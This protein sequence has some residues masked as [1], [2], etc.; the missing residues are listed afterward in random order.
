MVSY[1]NA[2]SST[3]S[4]GAYPNGTT[5]WPTPQWLVDQLAAEFAP[6]GF[7]LDPAASPENTKAPEYFTAEVDGLTRPWHGRVWCNPPY[8]KTSTP[9]WLAKAKAEVDQGRAD[10][11]VCLV[12]ARVETSWWRQYEADPEVFTRVIGR[13]KWS[14][15]RRGEAPF[16]SAIIVFGKLTGRHGKYPA[17]CANP[18]CPHPYRR[19]WPAQSNRQTCSDRCRK[20]LS[21]S[22]TRT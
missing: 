10:L 9:R 21:R 6:E 14:A 12:P 3:G 5:E 16:A 17:V 7:N 15:D 22:R 1:H 2:A 11:A 18:A 20:A 4:P 8:G 19:F 13:I